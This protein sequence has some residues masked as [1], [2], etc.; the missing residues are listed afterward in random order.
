MAYYTVPLQNT[1]RH[2]TPT[3]SQVVNRALRPYPTPEGSF[4]CRQSFSTHPWLIQILPLFKTRAY[5]VYL[6]RTTC[7]FEGLDIGL[8][9]TRNNRIEVGLSLFHLLVEIYCNGIHRPL[10]VERCG[11]LELK[12][13]TNAKCSVKIQYLVKAKEVQTSQ[14]CSQITICQQHRNKNPFVITVLRFAA[15]REFLSLLH[16]N[17]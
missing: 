10:S 2:N 7:G 8:A 3:Q 9:A 14:K 5:A 16:V 6:A 17:S 15:I 11:I 4:V 1:S 12:P 13:L